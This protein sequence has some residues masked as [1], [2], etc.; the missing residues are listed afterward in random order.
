MPMLAPDLGPDAVTC[1]YAVR[2]EL[3]GQPA[4]PPYYFSGGYPLTS[5]RVGGTEY[6]LRRAI[7]GR[8]YPSDNGHYEFVVD[9]LAAYI[10]GR[11]DTADSAA[12][13][14][15]NKL[16]AAVQQLLAARPFEMSNS[17]VARWRALESVI[18]M[19]QYRRTTPVRMRQLGRVEYLRHP[20]PKAIHWTGTGRERIALETMPP[21]FAGFKP[22]QWIEA[23]CERDPL[24]GR[25]LR[26]THVE[27]IP[28]LR[29]MS[30]EQQ[31]EFLQSL[32]RGDSLPESDLDWTRLE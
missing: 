14:W 21:E 8:L 2:D 32:P 30:R 16:H 25:L 1:V 24:T 4:R 27:P 18:D 19:A 26:V 9:A 20:F 23:I 5:I 31:D 17:D 13:D 10:V 7:Q 15:R 28:A 12:D 3:L 29:F 11:G 6:E 22:G